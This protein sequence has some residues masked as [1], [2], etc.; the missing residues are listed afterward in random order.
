MIKISWP[1]FKRSTFAAAAYL[2][3]S[4]VTFALIYW[5]IA[6]DELDRFESL[7]ELQASALSAHLSGQAPP[8]LD[9]NSFNITY[10]LT[11]SGIFNPD[12]AYAQ[13]NLH[14]LPPDLPLDGKAHFPVSGAKGLHGDDSQMIYVGMR[15]PDRR[16]LVI[17]RDTPEVVDLERTVKNALVEGVFPLSLVFV[18]VGAI[19]SGRMKRRLRAAQNCL[20]EIKQGDLKKRLTVSA[21]NDEFDSLAIAVNEMLA[22]LERAI[23]ELHH[24][25]DHIAHDLR[26][27]LSRIRSRLELVQNS[28]ELP[29][30][31]QQVVDLSVAGLDQ[32]LAITTAMLRVAQIEA[33]RAR[34]HFSDVNLQDVLV[35]LLELYDPLAESRGIRMD[36]HAK[37]PALVRGDRD[38]LME[39]ISNLIDN[40]I[41]F[42]PTN[43]M[44]ELKLTSTAQEALIQIRDFG[45]GI[46]QDR[47]TE[48]FERFYR[49]SESKDV[50][51]T[52]LGLTLVA[53]IARLHNFQIDIKDAAPGCLFELR[54][55]DLR[56]QAQLIG[57][58]AVSLVQSPEAPQ[59]R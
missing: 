51:G 25:G 47:R 23:N 34:A 48:V 58:S 13:G 31:L 32:T 6:F 1:T 53:A 22:E 4:I 27:P 44:I 36:L 3:A 15:L 43:G 55:S 29:D 18:G 10:R 19:A 24:V 21:A 20:D 46:P 42:S 54:F 12:G 8:S 17:G 37:E 16:V 41:K 28:S 26:A 30:H 33:G 49:C 50:P 5:K 35:E 57:A 38:L 9:D 39:A 7:L 52:G 59:P 2:S 56:P 45:P 11:Q 14:E 40:A